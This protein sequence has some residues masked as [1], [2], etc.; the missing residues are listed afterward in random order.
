M[1]TRRAGEDDGAAVIEFVMMSILLVLLLFVVL[2]VAVY[3]YAR[4]IV[5]AAAADA[6]RYAATAGISTRAGDE[7]ARELIEAGL[8]AHTAAQFTCTTA[9]GVQDGLPVTTVHCKGRM[10][11]LLAPADIPIVI[12]VTADSLTEPADPYPGGATR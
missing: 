4:N 6:A 2:Q 7:R 11:A 5:S 10:R 9:Q 12:D 8:N 3:F 1:R